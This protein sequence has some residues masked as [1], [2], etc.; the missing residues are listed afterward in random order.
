MITVAKYTKSYFLIWNEFVSSAKNATFLFHRDF[1]EYHQDR[2]ED[3]SLL[4]F[5]DEELI[6]I[7]PGN[8]VGDV[9]YSHQGL[10]YG[11]LVLQEK[12]KLLTAFDAFQAILKFLNQNSIVKLEVKIIP[13]FYNRL[14]SD[15]LEYFMFKANAK[16]VKRDILMVINYQNQIPFQKNRREGI[17]KAIRNG[18]QIKVDNNF[19]QFWNEILIPNLK[20]KHN[21]IPVHSLVEI[22]KIATNFPK[23]IQQINVYDG[24]KIVAGSTVFLTETT[25]HP[26]YV[27]GNEDK[28]KLGSLD[29]LYNF[30]IN[31]YVSNKQYFD[32]NISSESAGS[33]LNSGL[34][35]WKEGCGARGIV[36][37]NYEVNTSE[38]SSLKLNI[39]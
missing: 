8:R 3:Y 4:C 19:D 10:T 37:N 36:A 16:L 33:V 15:E 1:M 12:S 31:D 30:I 18:L 39:K 9:V 21:T 13:P 20:K 14:P 6:A 2:F 11:G 28:N 27:S 38:Y 23:N 5:K 24:D 34:I 35:F 26:Q 32:F 29:L 25:I 7:L 22:K 17:N